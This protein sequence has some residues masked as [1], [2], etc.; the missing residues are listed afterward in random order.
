MFTFQQLFIACLVLL[1]NTSINAFTI[2][3]NRKTTSLGITT[4]S[5]QSQLFSESG[6]SS[7]AAGPEPLTFREAEVLGLRLMQEGQHEAAL[8]GKHR[9]HPS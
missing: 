5:I 1:Q 9:S 7:S 2:P 8:K 4:G 6:G 3:K